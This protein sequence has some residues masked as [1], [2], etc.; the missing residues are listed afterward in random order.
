MAQQPPQPPP[1][2][3]VDRI[4]GQLRY[5][6]DERPELHDASPERI[7]ARLSLEDRYARARAQYPLSTDD[8]IAGRV[9]EF[10]DRLPLAV[11]EQA[12]RTLDTAAHGPRGDDTPRWLFAAAIAL[13]TAGL[14]AWIVNLVDNGA[15]RSTWTGGAL[16]VVMGAAVSAAV[17]SH[18]DGRGAP[19]FRSAN[20]SRPTARP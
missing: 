5:L 8:E 2:P 10:D 13:W 16:L 11:V 15:T 12:L 20:G 18:R 9:R 6:L 7:R 4:A 1:P 14:V 19:G 3:S 17:A